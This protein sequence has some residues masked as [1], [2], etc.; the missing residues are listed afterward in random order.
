[1]KESFDFGNP[2]DDALGSWPT[3]EQL[4]GFRGFAADFYQVYTFAKVELANSNKDI[5]V[6]SAYKRIAGMSFPRA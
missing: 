4:P 2:K 1:M 6:F 3:E 5:G